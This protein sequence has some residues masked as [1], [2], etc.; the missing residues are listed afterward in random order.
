MAKTDL[1][2]LKQTELRALFVL[3]VQSRPLTNQDLRELAGTDLSG[4][5][6]EHLKSLGLVTI[7]KVGRTNHYTLDDRGGRALRE[8]YASGPLDAVGRF[9]FTVLSGLQAGL[10]RRGISLGEFFQ[11]PITVADVMKRIRTAYA[12]RPKAAGGWVGLAELRADLAD[13][14]PEDIDAALRKLAGQKGVRLAPFDNTRSLRPQDKA[15]A[16]QLGD[17]PKHMIAMGQA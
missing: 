13:L 8:P 10:D 7:E 12:Q 5:R 1:S 16:L 4:G 3:M 14:S 17:S 9:I 11:P 15:A 6:G 2:Q